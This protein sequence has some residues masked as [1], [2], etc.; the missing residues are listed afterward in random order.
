MSGAAN[1]VQATGKG[2]W[3]VNGFTKEIV[4]SKSELELPKVG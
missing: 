3:P 1:P 2:S 4:M